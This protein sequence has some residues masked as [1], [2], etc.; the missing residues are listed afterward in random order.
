V[1]RYPATNEIIQVQTWVSSQK[2]PFT[3]REYQILDKDGGALVRASSL[4]FA[5][6]YKTRKPV[7]ITKITQELPMVAGKKSYPGM[8][9]KVRERQQL[10]TLDEIPVKLK[11]LDYNRH[12]NNV[13]Y[14]EWIFSTFDSG[15]YQDHEIDHIVVNFISE[16]L[17]DSGSVVVRGQ[18]LSEHVDYH[19]VD[20][21]NGE[22]LV[23]LETT[24]RK[25]LEV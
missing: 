4:W 1:D 8:P 24:W 15:K 9:V 14:L 5:V 16:A 23:R 22:V 6:D 3:E 19:Q 18:V 2:G 17:P 20:A 12:V 7:Q 10:N 11:D 25:A 13:K 21:R